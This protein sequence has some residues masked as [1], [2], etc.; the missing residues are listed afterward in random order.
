MTVHT[1]ARRSVARPDRITVGDQLPLVVKVIAAIPIAHKAL[2]TKVR[3]AVPADLARKVEVQLETT[4]LVDH[5]QKVD[6]EVKIA[7]RAK[8]TAPVQ[9]AAP[10]KAHAMM[11][12]A[13]ERDAGEKVAV[14]NT[15]RR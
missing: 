3:I 11:L 6:L 14:A 4:A 9:I 10:T 7:V 8:N 1:V 2:L 15:A 13:E 12:H 5:T